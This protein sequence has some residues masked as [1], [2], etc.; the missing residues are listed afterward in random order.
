M[1]RLITAESGKPLKW[2]VVNG[3][4]AR[5]EGH[6]VAGLSEWDVRWEPSELKYSYA[7][8]HLVVVPLKAYVAACDDDY[9]E[10][11]GSI[12]YAYTP[13]H[14]RTLAAYEI[15][16]DYECMYAYRAWKHEPRVAL[17]PEAGCEND[18]EYLRNEGW[19]MDGEWACGSCGLAA[20]G[21]E[22]YGVCRMCNQCKECGCEEDCDQSEGFSCE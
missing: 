11:F 15:N 7:E 14:A 10:Q 18:P 13:Q 8:E 17:Q 4:Q 12:V 3:A 20:N 2:E 9:P 19:H 1:A 22:K 21:Q 6:E 5:K 16:S